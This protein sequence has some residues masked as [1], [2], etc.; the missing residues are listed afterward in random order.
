MLPAGV[1]GALQ[2]GDCG[3]NFGSV[4]GHDRRIRLGMPDARKQ[5]DE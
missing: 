5:K 4:V 1:D 2:C 3:S